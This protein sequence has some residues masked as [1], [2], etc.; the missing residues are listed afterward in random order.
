MSQN[1][2]G[3]N[4]A[5]NRAME[6][7]Y[8]YSQGNGYFNGLMTNFRV[9][10]GTAVYTSAFTAPINPLTAITNTQL[11]LSVTSSGTLVTDSST[12]NL[13]VTNTGSATYSSTT[14]IVSSAGGGIKI[15]G[16][17][18]IQPEVVAVSSGSL[19]FNSN[20]LSVAGGTGTAMG[21]GDFTWECWVYPTASTSYQAFI[22][23]RTSPLSGGDTTGFY[24]GTN[25]GTLTPMYYTNGLQLASS[26]NIT[27][28][29]WNHVALTR[30][31][32]T[33]TIWVNGSSGGTKSDTTT[34]SQQ[35]IFIGS[36]GLDL[37]LKGRI[38][39]LRIVKG[40]AV[41]T[42]TFTPST[43]P[44]TA[45]SGTQLLLNTT[46]DANFL[47]D[48]STNNFTVT[49]NGSVTSSSLNPF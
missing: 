41:Y 4:S 40:T 12:N 23:T 28:N 22:D 3:Y 10:K 49:N 44:L 45:I 13:T 38:S 48:S 32:G 7:A 26:R 34:L 31:S 47:K 19:L 43:S 5:S 33:V 2:I 30:A 25:T 35:R 39:N 8:S 46:N 42:T 27:L 29:A 17:V 36:S 20:Y 21:T 9:V 14:P 37:Y 24:F 16:G 11:L 18:S 1:G 15:T 6:I